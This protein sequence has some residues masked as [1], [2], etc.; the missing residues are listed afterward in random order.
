MWIASTFQ[1]CI[2]FNMLKKKPPPQSS[3][4][5]LAEGGQDQDHASVHL[6]RNITSILIIISV[7]IFNIPVQGIYPRYRVYFLGGLR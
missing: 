4:K 3:S 2:A 5:S 7:G 1:Y 6:V